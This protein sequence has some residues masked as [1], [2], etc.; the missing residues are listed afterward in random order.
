MPGFAS[1]FAEFSARRALSQLHDQLG[2]AG[3]AAAA[4]I[5]GL[6]AAV[7][8]HAAAVRDIVDVGVEDSATVAGVVVLAGYARGMLDKAKELGWRVT[9]PG[10]LADWT[11]TDWLTAR[12]VAVCA[13]ANR[14]VESADSAGR[15]IA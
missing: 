14:P 1:A 7:D 9:A 8:Q 12:L 4:A 5:P 15:L 13:L 10:H 3:L 6:G 11:R 2:H